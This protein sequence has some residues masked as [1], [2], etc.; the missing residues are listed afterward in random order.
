MPDAVGL[1][2]LEFLEC[3]SDVA[4]HGHVGSARGV[5]PHECHAKEAFSRPISGDVIQGL[6]SGNHEVYSMF[7]ANAF[8]SK[9]IDDKAEG[10]GTGGMAE[11]AG[12]VCSAG[13]KTFQGGNKYG[14]I[15]AGH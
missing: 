7:S 1:F 14:M 5:V 10:D 6:K 8:D 4:G 2:M 9:V 3:F 13:E 11:E 15:D 12:S